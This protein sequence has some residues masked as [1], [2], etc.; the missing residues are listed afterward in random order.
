MYRGVRN[1]HGHQ[2]V[3]DVANHSVIQACRN[4]LPFDKLRANGA[5][6]AEKSV[7]GSIAFHLNNPGCIPMQKK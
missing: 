1:R 5:G 3:I 6:W 2:D 4:I 7:D